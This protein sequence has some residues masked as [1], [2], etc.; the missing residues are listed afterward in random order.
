MLL[1]AQSLCVPLCHLCQAISLR[2]CLAPISWWPLGEQAW[3]LAVTGKQG[4]ISVPGKRSPMLGEGWSG[5]ARRK[6]PHPAGVAP[7]GMELTRTE[8]RWPQ[9]EEKLRLPGTQWMTAATDIVA[10]SYSSC[11]RLFKIFPVFQIP[12]NSMKYH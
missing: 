7:Q 4:A 12:L 11:G 6:N 5:P 9:N 10:F 8:R 3:L 1:C 2:F